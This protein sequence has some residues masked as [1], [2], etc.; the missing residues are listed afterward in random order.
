MEIM[1]PASFAG[2]VPHAHDQFD[3]GIYVLR[4]RLPRYSLVLAGPAVHLAE[5]IAAQY[6]QLVEASSATKAVLAAALQNLSLRY[7]D[8][9]QPP[10]ALEAIS[11]AVAIRRTDAASSSGLW[12]KLHIA[13]LHQAS[14]YDALGLTDSAR[15]AEREGAQGPRIWPHAAT[16]EQTRAATEELSSSVVE[17]L[18]GKTIVNVLPRALGVIVPV[19]GTA[20]GK[21]NL[22]LLAPQLQLS[23]V[24]TRGVA[25]VTTQDDQ[26]TVEIHMTEGNDED[27][28]YDTTAPTATVEEL[29]AA[30]RPGTGCGRR[31]VGN[32]DRVWRGRSAG[33]G[34]A[35]AR[36][37]R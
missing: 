12:G 14:C 9:G 37:S 1:I 25:W 15:E 13:L 10:R 2:P 28:D 8:A 6:R 11:E 4:G 22:I 23:F 36:S 27:P 24:A 32:G 16:E 29:A 35:T 5:R 33:A 26:R 17:K 3:E 19:L 20:S 21:R 7:T 31:G 30:L 34:R 18:A